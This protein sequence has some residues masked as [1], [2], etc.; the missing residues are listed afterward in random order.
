LHALGVGAGGG[1][2]LGDSW[3][4]DVVGARAAGIRAVWFNPARSPSPD[5]EL[6]VRELHALEPVDAAIACLLAS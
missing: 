4:A 5:P 3:M 6:G 1:G 2:V